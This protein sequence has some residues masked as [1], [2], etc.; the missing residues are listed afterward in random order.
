MSLRDVFVMKEGSGG[1]YGALT[2]LLSDPRVKSIQIMLSP[3]CMPNQ[4]DWENFAVGPMKVAKSLG[5]RSQEDNVDWEGWT[6]GPLMGGEMGD[7]ELAWT[8]AGSDASGNSVS[9]ELLPLFK[10]ANA[11]SDGS[12]CVAPVG[13]DPDTVGA[14]RIYS[15]AFGATMKKALKK[16]EPKS[17]GKDWMN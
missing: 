7:D 4:D 13:V 3:A 10:A 9:G 1:R 14:T 11:A 15:G 8:N 6:A 16:D 17:S 5:W 2:K 12:Y